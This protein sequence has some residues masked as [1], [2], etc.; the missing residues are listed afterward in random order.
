MGKCALWIFSRGLPAP[1][2][3]LCAMF[4]LCTRGFEQANMI[5][6]EYVQL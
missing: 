4:L 5:P 1:S 3:P 6:K 2:I